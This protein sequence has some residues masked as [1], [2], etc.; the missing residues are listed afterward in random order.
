M[1]ISGAKV[2]NTPPAI[3]GISFFNLI[4]HTPEF[5]HYPWIPIMVSP[6]NHI[7]HHKINKKHYAAPILNLDYIKGAQI[8]QKEQAQ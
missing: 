1:H 3:T 6:N 8:S 4:I 7:T 5:E 2:Q